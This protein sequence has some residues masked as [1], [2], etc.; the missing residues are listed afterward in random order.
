MPTNHGVYSRTQHHVRW[1]GP[2]L[3]PGQQC[4]GVD[5]LD[6]SNQLVRDVRPD[7]NLSLDGHARVFGE[8]DGRVE[9]GIL[10]LCV[11]RFDPVLAK[12]Q[13]R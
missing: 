5:V 2:F 7:E 10:A 6:R 9:D 3:P 8:F 1:P 12:Q 4:V 13:K 11:L